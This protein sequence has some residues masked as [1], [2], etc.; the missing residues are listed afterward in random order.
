MVKSEITNKI[1]KGKNTGQFWIVIH[2]SMSSIQLF[3]VEIAKAM[4]CHH[5]VPLC[6]VLKVGTWVTVGRFL[7]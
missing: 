1:L 4:M 6:A 2:I 3:F 5:D 7:G